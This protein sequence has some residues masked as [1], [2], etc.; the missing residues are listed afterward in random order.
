MNPQDAQ[1]VVSPMRARANRLRWWWGQQLG[2]PAG[3]GVALLLGA[4]WLL[5]VVRP[6]YDSTLQALLR[7]HVATLDSASRGPVAVSSAGSR[8]P[9]DA[10]RD[11]WPSVAARGESIAQLVK[12]LERE[13]VVADRAEY[14]TE[15]QEPGLARLRI[16]VPVEGRYADLRALIAAVL[17]GLPHAALDGLQLERQEGDASRLSGTLRLSLF[18]RQEAP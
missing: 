2:W 10:M 6:G 17:N 9:R 7:A 4:A 14:T 5:L 11:S 8:D 16:T 13:G 3:L 18:F 1:T 12:L 15:D